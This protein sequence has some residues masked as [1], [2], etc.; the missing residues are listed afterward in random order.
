MPID[1]VDN[2][3]KGANNLKMSNVNDNVENAQDEPQ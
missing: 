1:K 3:K 2:K